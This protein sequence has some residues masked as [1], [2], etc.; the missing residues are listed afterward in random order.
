MKTVK[1]LF[2]ML[3]FALTASG[4]YAKEWK[5]VVKLSN[6]QKVTENITLKGGVEVQVA[7]KATIQGTITGDGG[8]LTVNGGTLRIENSVNLGKQY[9]DIYIIVDKGELEISDKAVITAQGILPRNGTKVVIDVQQGKTYNLNDLLSADGTPDFIKRGGGQLIVKGYG[10]R[11][12]MPKMNIIVEA[13]RLDVQKN[14]ITIQSVDVKSSA[15]IYLNDCTVAT[16]DVPLTGNGNVHF[17]DD[18]RQYGKFDKF[19]GTLYLDKGSLAMR[20]S[21][22]NLFTVNTKSGTQVIV[23]ADAA[24]GDAI[25]LYCNI[26]GAGGVYMRSSYG[27]QINMPGK[28]EYSGKTTL[29]NAWLVLNQPSQIT[30]TS[31]IILAGNQ[32]KLDISC[33]AS[34]WNFNI[35]IS[36]TGGAV[37]VGGNVT[38]GGAIKFDGKLDANKLTTSAG[39]ADKVIITASTVNAKEIAAN[40]GVKLTFNPSADLTYAGIIT[41]GG[42]SSVIKDGTKKLKLTGKQAS[43]APIEVK[44]GELEFCPSADITYTRNL[45]GAGKIS[46]TGTKKLVL[47]SAGNTAI[48]ELHAQNGIMLVKQVWKGSVKISAASL[49]KDSKIATS[50]AALR[51]SKSEKAAIVNTFIKDFEASQ[52]EFIKAASAQ[53]GS[54]EAS[55]T[56]KIDKSITLDGGS[57]LVY[58]DATVDIDV[59]TLMPASSGTQVKVTPVLISN[60][61]QIKNAGKG[62]EYPLV[63]AGQNR[64]L[65]GGFLIEPRAAVIG[66]YLEF[67]GNTLYLVKGKSFQR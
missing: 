64:M 63:K 46:K 37:K 45:S 67:K 57:I 36:G 53:F 23:D 56:L 66:W 54:A 31:E 21:Q 35:P 28:N 47:S 50:V 8:S 10:G 42:Q 49:R 9:L 62:T 26:T 59:A 13:G 17:N 43:T 48:G 65:I 44:G 16:V 51:E 4:I 19:Y 38:L 22:T 24:V 2:V 12:G 15:E 30:K 60:F 25:Q 52:R 1:I 5:G 3:A 58:A 32:S 33:S 55:S 18:T 27:K 6:G 7:G 61:D 11:V 14:S 34:N 40:G 41:I 29:D 20:R 39:V